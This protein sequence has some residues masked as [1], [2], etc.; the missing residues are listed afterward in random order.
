MRKSFCV[1][2]FAIILHA[3][4]LAE[5]P[6]LEDI[7][8]EFLVETGVNAGY[9]DHI[10]C[11]KLLFSKI[12]VKNLLEF[13]MGYSTKYFLD[14][15][16]KVISVEFL[17]AGYGPYWMQKLLGLYSTYSN[18]VPIAYCSG[19]NGDMS[20]SPYKFIG[21]D[22]VMKANNHQVIHK[23]SYISVDDAYHKELTT[24][25]NNLTK[26]NKITVALVDPALSIRGELVQMLFGK[27][28]IIITNHVNFAFLRMQDDYYGYSRISLPDNYEEIHI[29]SGQGTIVWIKKDPEW[30]ELIQEFKNW[31]A[32]IKPRSL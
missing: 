10:P 31:A 17:T 12:K 9:C 16:N 8:Y 25:V 3:S 19:Y 14:H 22:G 20:W 26:Y 30:E 7:T 24:F 13:G 28:P 5:E 27:S 21:S 15:C 32:F 29:Q 2:L 6:K 1:A 18:W 23:K 4:V 11:F